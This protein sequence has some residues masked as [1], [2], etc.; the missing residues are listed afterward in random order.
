MRC[1]A[2]LA[3]A[4]LWALLACSGAGAG[5]TAYVGATLWDGT[6]APV[7]H[8]AVIIVN[9]ARIEEIGPPDLVKVPRGAERVH[10]TSSEFK[11][12]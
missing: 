5:K 12:S 8:D 2:F 11:Q 3:P 7:I 10:P 4:A 1:G 6:G 9:G